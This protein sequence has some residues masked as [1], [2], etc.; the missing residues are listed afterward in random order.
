MILGDN[1]E[2]RRRIIRINS[3]YPFDIGIEWEKY[4]A[5][6]DNEVIRDIQRFDDVDFVQGSPSKAYWGN[7]IIHGG[8]GNDILHGQRG[9]DEIHGD[10]GEDELYGELGIDT[11]L[12]GQGNDIVLGDVGYAI[13][14]FDS[15]G[16]PL[17]TSQKKWHKDIVLEEVGMIKSSH[18]I[19]TKV[20]TSEFTA[21]DVASSSLLIV[22]SEVGASVASSRTTE[23]ILFDLVPSYDDI[24]E[25][26][27]DDDL[28]IGQRG[29]D[30][31][32]GGTGNDI[33]IGDSGSNIVTYNMDIPR[34]FEICRALPNAAG[35]NGGYD[36]PQ[37]GATFMPNFAVRP[38]QYR[39]VDSLATF[40]DIVFT[41]NS[42]LPKSNLLSDI[43]GIS[44]L[45]K[46]SQGN[47]NCFQ[48]MLRITPGFL[49][50]TQQLH[51][52]DEISTG[53]GT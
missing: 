21:E 10:K 52:N 53:S 30:V 51:G 23:A 3:S 26:G 2:I 27:E 13:R 20:N 18:V 7:D 25:G 9:N 4:P 8:S 39:S 11:L 19:S 36:V 50:D 34:I 17:L 44:G 16:D 41:A 45:S 5:P 40:S 33:M 14:R 49:Y 37:F 24:L 32:R 22:A 29:N 48:P 31:L 1:G 15:S 42:V 28:L 6:F 43:I 12:G 47:G 38:Q 35:D 46:S